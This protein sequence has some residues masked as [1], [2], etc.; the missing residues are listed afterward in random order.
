MK[1]LITG[2]SYSELEPIIKQF[3]VA[4][5]C[6]AEPGRLIHAGSVDFLVSGIGSVFTTL[7]LT[8]ALLQTDYDLLIQAGI[9]GSFEEEFAP[10]DICQIISERF[11]DL[12]AEDHDKFLDIFDMNLMDP[13]TAPFVDGFLLNPNQFAS[14]FIQAIPKAKAITVNTVHGNASSISKIKK[15]WHPHVESMEG[16]AFFLASLYAGVPF[17]EIRS[18][19]NYITPRNRSDWEIDVAIHELSLIIPELISH[20]LSG[21]ISVNQFT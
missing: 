17:L 15:R 8:R 20:F 13:D 12:G 9:C 14:P 18:V 3:V 7:H 4:Q 16:A 1:V 19:S 21:D 11:S 10:G 5:D 2:A 6:P